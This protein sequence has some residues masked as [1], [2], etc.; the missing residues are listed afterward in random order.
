MVYLMAAFGYTNP[1]ILRRI[2][3]PPMNTFVAIDQGTTSTRSILFDENF[4]VLRSCQK[5]FRQS[6]PQPGW[7]EHDAGEIWDTVQSTLEGLDLSANSPPIAI[8]ITNQRETSVVWE[9][10]SGEPAAPAIV[11]QDRRTAAETDRLREQGHEPFI[12]E[13]TGLLLDPYFSATKWKWLLD[14]IPGGFSRA[15][16]GDLMLGTI[17]SWLIYK[18]TSGDVHVTDVS[19]AS[20]TLLMN[21]DTGKWDADLLKLF[22]IPERALPQIVPTAYNFGEANISGLKVPIT[23]SIGDQQAALFG[24][25]CHV[26]GLA[27][28]TYGTGCF[29]LTFT[30]DKLLRS[31]NRLLSTAAWQISSQPLQYAIEGSVFVGGAVIQWLRDGLEMIGSSPDVNGLAAKVE[32]A[33]GV[34]FVPAFTGLGAPHWDPGACG[35][36]LGLSRGTTAAHIAHAAIEGI[37]FQVDDVLRATNADASVHSSGNTVSGLR[38][39]GGASA[40]DLLMQT[41]SDLSGL[42]IER[43]EV[44][45]STARGAAMMAALQAGHFGCIEDFSRVA[46]AR[47]TF[48]PQ[49][50]QTRQHARRSRWQEAV[51]RVMNWH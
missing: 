42:K 11:W 43:P 37:A 28:C 41:Q 17:E 9:R 45:E 38:V 13:R 22:Q 32:D 27:K 16:R 5:E 12:Q 31:N 1:P 19:N 18:L 50:D 46:P 14:S 44:V 30:G 29:L 4:T 20:R 33:G 48:H 40:S 23:S 21:L 8:G 7:V 35:G 51:K 3:V 39:D 49:L 25:H 2:T 47:Q 26:P 24:Q 36:I 10:T 15:E 34:V 6:F